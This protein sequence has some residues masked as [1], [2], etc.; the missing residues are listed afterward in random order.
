M[1]GVLKHDPRE[2]FERFHGNPILTAPHW[3]QMVNAVFNPGAT[4][5]EGETLLLVRVEDRTGLS[6][7]E[8]ARSRDGYTDWIIEPDRA[9]LPDLDSHDE[10]WGV[11]DARITKCGDD[12]LV[13][14]TGF[15]ESGPLVCLASTQD[16]RTFT[17]HGVI[18]SPEDKDGAL[19]PRQFDGRWA[20]V[21]R[22]VPTMPGI[23]THV[24]LSWSQDL[25]HW[26]DPSMLIAAR[27]GGWW[28]ANKVGL[29]P[30]PLRTDQGWLLCYHGVKVT[31]SGS[32]YRLGLAL[33]DL[34]HPEQIIARSNEWVF[35][36]SA[37]YERAGD[38]AD[39]V[40]PCG[41]ILEDDGDTVRMYY[42]AADTSVC[43]ATAHLS[44]LLALLDRH[45]TDSA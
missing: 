15:S 9:I 1:T 14:Y 5:F 8:V 26:G 44:D 40:F 29:G 10:K 24:W 17:K 45:P 13:V 23:G 25:R 19:F 34:D 3:P 2:V 7:L 11:E 35:G 41:W 16:F 21:H 22:P 4:E 43:V 42:G 37:P 20:L 39:V 18:M 30:P 38:V 32:V 12:Y 31:V 6:R 27:K 28:D 36:P 33:A